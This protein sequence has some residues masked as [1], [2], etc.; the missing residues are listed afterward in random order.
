MKLER[1]HRRKTWK[2]DVV[3]NPRTVYVGDLRTIT[4]MMPLSI[5]FCQ[6][7]VPNVF[8]SYSGNY[9]LPLCGPVFSTTPPN[10]YWNYDVKAFFLRIDVP[11]HLP[12]GSYTVNLADWYYWQ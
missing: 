4:K 12:Q 9:E 7:S 1:R 8:A 11:A 5:P 6:L 2:W 3:N 10:Q